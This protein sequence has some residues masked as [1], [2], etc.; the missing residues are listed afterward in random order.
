MRPLG[1]LGGIMRSWVLVAAAVALAGC[2]NV[3]ISLGNE[4]AG[5]ASAEAVPTSGRS[6][7]PTPGLYSVSVTP[8]IIGNAP[9]VTIPAESHQACYP[10]STME[11]PD[12]F[13]LASVQG[14][15][16]QEFR[17]E[18]GEVYARLTC[19][20]EDGDYPFEIRGSYDTEGAEVVGDMTFSDGSIRVN[21]TLKRIG[22]C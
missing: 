15:Q 1:V 20:D 22:D 4:T 7:L 12:T 16:R 9:P 13:L 6:D 17:V 19:S 3:Q 21:R 2:D 5:A 8:Q 10:K 14:C 11:R 18:G